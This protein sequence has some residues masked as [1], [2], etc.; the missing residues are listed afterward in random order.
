MWFLRCQQGNNGVYLLRPGHTYTI[1]RKAGDILLP[2]DKS[3][4]R[5]HAKITIHA[6]SMDDIFDGNKPE[7]TLTDC[8]SKYGTVAQGKKFQN[9]TVSAEDQ[10]LILFGTLTSVFKLEWENVRV[11]LASLTT[12][13]RRVACDLA[14]KLGITISRDWSSTC[15]HLL[16]GAVEPNSKLAMCLLDKR[17]VVSLSWLETMAQTSDKDFSFPVR[18]FTPPC[19]LDPIPNLEVEDG[20]N[21]VFAGTEFWFFESEQFDDYSE[22]IQKGDGKPKLSAIEKKYMQKTISAIHR[23]IVRPEISRSSPHWERIESMLKKSALRAIDEEEIKLAIIY[24]STKQACNPTSPPVQPGN[25]L[26]IDT[27]APSLNPNEQIS[28]NDSLFG[29]LDDE[30]IPVYRRE[31]RQ[32]ASDDFLGGFLDDEPIKADQEQSE[33]R[34]AVESLFDDV[35]GDYDGEDA[36]P[37]LQSSPPSS[38]AG[39]GSPSS[40]PDLYQP[41]SSRPVPS[42]SGRDNLF[43]FLDE[44][45]HENQARAPSSSP[46]LAPSPPRHAPQPGRTTL[47]AGRDGLL[48]FFERQERASTGQEQEQQQ[49]RQQPS[50]PVSPASAARRRKIPQTNAVR[51]SSTE[52]EEEHVTKKTRTEP[53]TSSQGPSSLVQDEVEES[54]IRDDFEEQEQGPSTTRG[55]GRPPTSK[56][57]RNDALAARP[58]T[59][60][61]RVQEGEEQGQEPDSQAQQ[62]QPPAALEEE[63][64]EFMPIPGHRYTAIITAHLVVSIPPVRPAHRNNASPENAVINYKSFRKVPPVYAL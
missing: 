8:N 11:C 20:R 5:I 63:P 46:V 52:R 44:E 45:D 10:S 13:E 12:D 2:N 58:A 24:N 62:E 59:R 56:R 49:S 41:S 48:G 7:V 36:K 33:F 42:T 18:A 50:S 14:S 34:P 3:I 29:A 32:S 31:H 25:S 22:M 30:N 40:P 47:N 23:V 28:D 17:R 16:M 15:T 60:R 51:S 39:I 53:R 35:F 37:V 6:C 21:T 43:D 61:R 4:S 64:G 26:L 1:G 19:S 9:T 38:R 27:P 54:D 55:R 57:A